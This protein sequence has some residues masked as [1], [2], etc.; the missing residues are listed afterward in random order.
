MIFGH[1]VLRQFYNPKVTNPRRYISI[2]SY[3][4]T[5][6]KGDEIIVKD[7]A[8]SYT[9]VVTAKTEVKPDDR[10][11]LEQQRNIRELKLITCVPEGTFLRR[12][13]ITAQLKEINK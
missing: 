2:F 4:M 3:I 13:V 11:I 1:S 9:Y 12:G 10:Y 6:K 7:D 5:L 8:I